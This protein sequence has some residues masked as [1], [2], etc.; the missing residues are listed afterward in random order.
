MASKCSG[1]N[2]EIIWMHTMSGKRMPVDAKSEKRFVVTGNNDEGE[3]VGAVR[4][5]YVSH[6]ATCPQADAFRKKEAP[7]GK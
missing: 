2:A 1:C 3:P 6:F 4:D 7:N 5:T